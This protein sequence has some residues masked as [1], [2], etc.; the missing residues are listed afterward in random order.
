MVSQPF[1]CH[2]RDP[3]KTVTDPGRNHQRFELEAIEQVQ[4]R[5]VPRSSSIAE[6]AQTSRLAL[7]PR[8]EAFALCLFLLR[9]T[10]QILGNF[11]NDLIHKTLEGDPLG[12]LRYEPGPAEQDI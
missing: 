10:A 3:G 9:G 2:K 4:V 1:L 6:A 7:E 8:T 11:S 12:S 5:R